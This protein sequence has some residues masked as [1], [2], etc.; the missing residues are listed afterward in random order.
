LFALDGPQTIG[1]LISFNA[2]ERGNPDIIGV[3]PCILPQDDFGFGRRTF[4]DI[5]AYLTWLVDIKKQQLNLAWSSSNDNPKDN[6]THANCHPP[7]ESLWNRLDILISRE[8]TGLPAAT[9][10]IVPA[11]QDFSSQNVVIDNTT[12]QIT[13]VFDWEYHALLPAALA[14]DYPSWIECSAE[15]NQTMERENFSSFWLVSRE[16]AP[17]L[18][19]EYDKVSRPRL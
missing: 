6:R 5:H 16:T 2:A 7:S 18:R 1:S 4:T 9:L 3:G 11:H 12:G 13:G 8:I 17:Q 10:R 15:S 19:A 14:A